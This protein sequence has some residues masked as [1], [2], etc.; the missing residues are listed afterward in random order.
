SLGSCWPTHR[1]LSRPRY[2]SGA[3]APSVCTSSSLAHSPARPPLRLD[4]WLR[5]TA[6]RHARPPG[7]LHLRRG[8]AGRV[9][10]FGEPGV[11]RHEGLRRA[12]AAYGRTAPREPRRALG[13]L[14]PRQRHVHHEADHGRERAFENLV[15]G[16]RGLDGRYSRRPHQFDG[17]SGCGRLQT[18][19]HGLGSLQ[20]D[21]RDS[22]L[23]YPGQALYD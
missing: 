7:Y 13:A 3:N 11:L 12:A 1:A 2:I 4:S 5:R 10:G 18:F 9:P 8:R 16:L 19:P 14:C 6:G 20:A 15:A 23:E 22:G 21:W 17:D